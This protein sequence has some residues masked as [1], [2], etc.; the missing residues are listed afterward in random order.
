MTTP[1]VDISSKFPE[2]AYT[3]ETKTD[4]WMLGQWYMELEGTGKESGRI[5]Y[6]RLRKDIKWWQNSIKTA[7]NRNQTKGWIQLSPNDGLWIWSL[8][9]WRMKWWNVKTTFWPD[10][11]LSGSDEKASQRS[12]VG[13]TTSC[14]ILKPKVKLKV[15]RCLA[16][17]DEGK[18]KPSRNM[19]GHP[20]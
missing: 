8:I 5:E 9:S 12:S 3:P 11:W 19:N 2:V 1:V 16:Y 4:T 10:P 13:Q 17:L 6:F 20:E 14:S 7:L 18:E 15:E